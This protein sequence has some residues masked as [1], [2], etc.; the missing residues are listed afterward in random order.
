MPAH[1]LAARYLCGRSPEDR[2]G[3]AAAYSGSLTRC[4]HCGNSRRRLIAGSPEVPSWTTYVSGVLWALAE[5]KDEHPELHLRDGTGAD[6][7]IRS[8]LPI[9]GG[10]SSS[11][12]LECAAAL[13]FVA[14]G[15][16][17]GAENRGDD[18][19]RAL[20]DS[21]RA[22]LAQV[23]VRAEVEAVGAGTGV[24]IRP[25]H[26]AQPKASWSRWTAGTSL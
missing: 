8:T 7:L 22:V 9:G 12:S 20:T 21:L 5:L 10:L 13:A 19:T 15:T 23:C 16:P 3:A 6:L 2:R 25:P 1:G 26:C 18:L 11:A 17:L 4:R 24:W 14:M